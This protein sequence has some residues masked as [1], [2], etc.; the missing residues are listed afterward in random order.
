MKRTQLLWL[1]FFV[2]VPAIGHA[3]VWSGILD[4]T[5]AVDWST[6]GVPGGI[7]NRTTICATIQASTYGNGSSDA[8][9]GIQ[10]A[11][12]ACPA[13][14]VALLGAGVFLIN[15][16]LV[17]PNNV[18][19]R[20]AGADQTQLHW[21]G[22]DFAAVYFGNTDDYSKWPIS[23]SG[24]TTFSNAVKGA[25]T[26]QVASASGISAGSM[27]MLTQRDLSYMTEAGHGGTCTFCTSGF[28][29][30]GDSGQNVVI[31]AVNGTTLTIDPPLYIDYTN[32]PTAFRFTH[33][34]ATNSGL[35]NL[36]ISSFGQ[37]PA[38]Q[39]ANIMMGAAY[40]S[41]VLGVESDFADNAH[42]YMYFDTHCE[43]R[44]SYFHDGYNHGPGQTDNQ[45]NIAYKTSASLIINN[46]F[47]R[48]HVSVMFERGSSGNVLAYNFM[49]GNYHQ[50]QLSWHQSDIDFHGAH[51]MMN[52]LEGNADDFVQ[53]D[54]YWGSSSH[55]TIFRNYA[56]GAHQY[57]PPL[58]A[59]GALQI[60]SAIWED[61]G[62][63]FAYDVNDLQNYNNLVGV[64]AGNSHTKSAGDAGVKVSP[65]SGFN[66]GVCIRYGYDGSNDA[67][68]NP[69]TV[70]PTTFIHGVYDCQAGTFTWDSAH[71]D[72]TLPASFFLSSKPTW[73][74]PYR[75]LQ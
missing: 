49:S 53:V 39:S 26:I 74:D 21:A 24:N 20:G 9:S 58:N 38:G 47:W 6:A 52:L 1:I 64:I 10:A 41:W 61:G 11:L 51:P 56:G 16:H 27:L 32:S 25:T 37:H 66:N 45:L 63:D 62:N 12:N 36:K 31:T 54:D 69:N 40:A 29:G 8:T 57:V 42:M 68:V 70:F 35:E 19:L 34:A 50:A 18:V 17:I 13:N 4:P 44:N 28:T 46:I 75:G 60:G 2:A 71:P 72:H 22:T 23:G 48:Q 14:Q 65:A 67:S 3:Q 5:R 73:W 43:V 15:S 30:D 59:R 33:A 7:P 55:T